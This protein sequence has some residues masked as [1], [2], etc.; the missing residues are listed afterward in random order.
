MKRVVLFI[1]IFILGSFEL[2]AQFEEEPYIPIDSVSGKKVR[3]IILPIVFYTP[4]TGFAFGGGGQLFLLERSNLY[5]LRK[6]NILLSGIYTLNGQLLIDIKPEIFFNKGDYFLDMSYTYKIFPNSFWG[7]GNNTPDS[8]QEGYNM[9]SNELTIGF[10]KRL[11]PYLNFGFEYTF[12]DYKITEVEEGGLL[13]EGSILGSNGARI[14][15]LGVVFNLDSRDNIASPRQGKL[16][17]LKA[18]FSSKNLG[19][20]SDF[21]RFNFDIRHYLPIGKSSIIAYQLYT[22]SVFGDVPFQAK[23]WYGGGSRARGYFRGRFMNDFIYVIQAEYRTKFHPRWSAAGF[24]LAGE[25]AEDLVHIFNYVKPSLGGGVRF[26]LTKEHDTMLRLDI[27]VGIDG[28]SGFY[29]GVNEA[30]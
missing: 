21:N 7:V 10:L 4:E 8:N 9:T 2:K 18:Q 23:P 3:S 29:F 5:N 24:I 30:F 14:S 1:L 19:A 20:S 25:V 6:S 16:L 27:G 12:N 28:N 13:E 15:G 26:K 17:Q 22:E 11:P